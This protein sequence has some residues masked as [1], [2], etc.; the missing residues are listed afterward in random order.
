MSAVTT[1]GAALAWL[2]A[3]SAHPWLVRHHELVLEAAT[4]VLAALQSILPPTLDRDFVLIGAA[5]SLI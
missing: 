2:T 3:R 5:R 1:P 4:E